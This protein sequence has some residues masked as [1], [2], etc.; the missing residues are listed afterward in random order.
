MIPI[1]RQ[2][3]PFA[4]TGMLSLELSEEQKSLM[5]GSGPAD[6]QSSSECI[7]KGVPAR[8]TMGLTSLFMSIIIN[9]HIQQ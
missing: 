4:A 5:S 1:H 7:V 2:K 6:I 8:T 9:E 3:R